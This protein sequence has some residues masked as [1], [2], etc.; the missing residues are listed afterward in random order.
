MLGFSGKNSRPGLVRAASLRFLPVLSLLSL[1]LASCA[2]VPPSRP[3]T[4]WLAVLPDLGPDSLYASVDVASSWSLVDSLAASVGAE[5]GELERIRGNL[6]RVH[7][8]IR[9]S[10]GASSGRAPQLYLIA[11]GSFSAG[12]I[13]RRLNSDSSWERIMLEPLPGGDFRSH[14]WS[15][16]TYWRK[17]QL[18]IAVPA[19]GIL[20]VT[21]GVPAGVPAAESLLRRLF[22]PQE[23]PLPAQAR[24][25]SE[26]AD[27]F[28]YIPNPAF[29]ASLWSA[30]STAAPAKA[31]SRVQEPGAL[32]QKLPI[33]QGWISARRQ[34]SAPAA[35]SGDRKGYELDAVFL[36]DQVDNPRS[37]ELLLRL[38][39]TLWLRK[40]R[41]EDPVETLK[42]ATI[43]ADAGSARIDSFF[44]KDREIAAFLQTLLP[45]N[46]GSRGRW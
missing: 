24:A 15:D 45:E 5:A 33:R 42:A 22:F 28:L 11:L 37:V 6:H 46:L 3:A 23:Q 7:A 4:G 25:E 41:A 27:I 10:S 18:E 36:L 1:L 20:F 19:R 9:L 39:L 29:L 32:L 8:H 12:S 14:H 2:T 34:V 30:S 26:S 31:A 13:A 16:R 40:V 17:D 43:S 38:M 35:P 21:A 44:L